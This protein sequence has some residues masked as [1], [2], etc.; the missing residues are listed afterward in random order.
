MVCEVNDIE[1]WS[2]GNRK[3]GSGE[4]QRASQYHTPLSPWLRPY[5]GWLSGNLNNFGRVA[6]H[7]NIA[8]HS[9]TEWTSAIRAL[10]K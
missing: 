7:N 8:I 2:L 10:D 5:I 3:L 9:K 4:Q 6:G 1:K